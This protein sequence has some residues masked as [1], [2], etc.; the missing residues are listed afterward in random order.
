MFDYIDRVVGGLGV[1][2]LLA[3]ALVVFIPAV[4]NVIGLSGDEVPAFTAIMWAIFI[5][6][7]VVKYAIEED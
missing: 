6:F 1:L 3:Y 2:G 4:A 7:R 5:A